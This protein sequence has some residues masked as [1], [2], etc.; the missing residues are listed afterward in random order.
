MRKHSVT[1]AQVLKLALNCLIRLWFFMFYWLISFQNVLLN[2]S[3]VVRVLIK[4]EFQV[5]V[6]CLKN[7]NN[8]KTTKQQEQQQLTNF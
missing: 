8:N 3:S 4:Y 6:K 7:N 5:F 2:V 1:L